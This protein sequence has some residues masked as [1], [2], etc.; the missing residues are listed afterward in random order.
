MCINARIV[1]LL[2]IMVMK[3]RYARSD[4]FSE[5]HVMDLLRTI[6]LHVMMDIIVRTP[7]NQM[8]SDSL[9]VLLGSFHPHLVGMTVITQHIPRQLT[10]RATWSVYHV[11]VIEI[12][13]LL[14]AIINAQSEQMDS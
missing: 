1:D 4:T 12:I 9:H 3:I 13:D 8:E 10:P 11:M 2:D 6:V 7:F 5:R 14:Q